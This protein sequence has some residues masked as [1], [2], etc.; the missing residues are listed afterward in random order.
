MNTMAKTILDKAIEAVP[1]FGRRIK[2]FTEKMRIVQY[3]FIN[4]EFQH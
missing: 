1:K 4:K 2:L 3:V